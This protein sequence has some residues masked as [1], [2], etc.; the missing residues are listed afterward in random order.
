APAAEAK[1]DDGEQLGEAD[2]QLEEGREVGRSIL[3]GV[4]IPAS[5]KGDFGNSFGG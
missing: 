4:Y 5:T 2:F 1:E 3:D